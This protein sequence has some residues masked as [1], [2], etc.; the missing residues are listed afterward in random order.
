MEQL[1]F[2]SVGLMVLFLLFF[3]LSRNTFS[4]DPSSVSLIVQGLK[5]QPDLSHFGLDVNLKQISAS[6]SSVAPS[7]VVT[8]LLQVKKNITT[9]IN[10][11]NKIINKQGF[12]SKN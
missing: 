11:K 6:A 1:N 12:A 10:N 7:E 8:R 9:K 4:Y 2:H 5:N 3:S